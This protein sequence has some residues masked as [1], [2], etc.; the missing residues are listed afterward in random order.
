MNSI[1]YT[2]EI[3]LNSGSGNYI[4]EDDIINKYENVISYQYAHCKSE[5]I[6]KC[7]GPYIETNENDIYIVLD[8]PGEDALIHW[9]TECFTFNPILI[10]LTE[11]YPN[12]KI[13]TTNTK[14]YV[15]SILKLFNI[16]NEICNTIQKQNNICF[17]LPLHRL[18]RKMRQNYKK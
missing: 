2:M 18:K 3:K 6:L 7:N 1:L 15:K 14:K 4:L 17:F 10:K 12:I 13:L 11:I 9:I 5:L 8:S 16:N